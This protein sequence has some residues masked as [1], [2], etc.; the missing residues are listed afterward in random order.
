MR[1]TTCRVN[2]FHP[3][4]EKNINRFRL[5][6]SPIAAEI[7]WIGREVFSWSELRRINKNRD[8]DPI[9]SRL[10]VTHEAQVALMKGAHSRHKNNTAALPPLGFAPMRHLCDVPKYPHR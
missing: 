6:Q 10:G 1:L 8:N 5:E 7:S 9:S 3:R 4:V 2:I